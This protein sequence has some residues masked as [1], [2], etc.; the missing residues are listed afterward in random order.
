MREPRPPSS[1]GRGWSYLSNHA[2]PHAVDYLAMLAV[3]D[4]IEIV[5]ETQSLSQTLQDVDAKSF[6]AA[7]YHLMAVNSTRRGER[8]S[9]SGLGALWKVNTEPA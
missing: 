8:N 7:L 2:V 4:K 3:G 9:A 1:L 6:A 5:G